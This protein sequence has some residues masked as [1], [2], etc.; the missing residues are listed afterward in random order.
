MTAGNWN[1]FVRTL[2]LHLLRLLIVLWEDFGI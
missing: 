1:E 2:V